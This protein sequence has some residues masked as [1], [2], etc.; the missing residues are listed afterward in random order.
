MAIIQSFGALQSMT[1][2]AP[3]WNQ[4]G[5]SVSL[6]GS[7]SQ[8]YAEI[9]RTQPNVRICID[10][11][12]RNIAQLGLHIFRR[13]SDTD[14]IRL[15]DHELARW[16]GK[17]NP[18]TRRYRLIETL[19]GDLGLYFNAFWLKVRYLD[20][21]GRP[22]I[23]LVRLP[24]ADMTVEGS[25]LPTHYTWTQN[26][27]R[28]EFALS[29]VVHFNG[30]NPLNPFMG[31]SP[32]ETLRRILA[33]EAAA[34]DH[35]EMFWRNAGRME[36][37]IEQTKDAP[38]WTQPQQ[39]QFRE[40]WQE[41]SAGGAKVGMTA[42][43]PKGMTLR[44]WSFS[45][46]DSEYTQGGKLRREVCAAAYH[47]PQPMVGIL[48]HATF[49]NIREQHKHLYQDTLGPW[50]EM[51]QQE[52]EG[53]LLIECEDQRDVYTEFNIAAKLSGSF[54]EQASSLQVLVGRPMM[55]P[56]EGRARL[57]LPSV[58][59]DPTA[60]QLA[61]QQGG[62]AASPEAA[63][64]DAARAKYYSPDDDEPTA[65][66]DVAAVIDATRERQR[67][68]LAKVPLVERPAVF[69]GDSERW[70]RE[71]ATDLLPLVR[72][73]AVAQRLARAANAETQTR[74]EGEAFHA[75]LDALEGKVDTP[76][77]MPTSPPPINLAFTVPDK[78]N[79]KTVTFR[80]DAQGAVVGADVREVA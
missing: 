78:S 48:D 6:Y 35:R 53:Q 56:N 57:N 79:A 52:I 64:P 28:K 26:G 32:L 42:V 5:S 68:R 39:D 70:T 65:R 63:A 46:K 2:P 10:F 17:P 59:D 51:I 33:E 44:P 30:Y 36:G 11:L 76:P 72:D 37:V 21:A 13:V 77:A 1:T 80:R 50:L 20:A 18:T 23:G 24:P 67:V 40:R 47:I 25:L 58:A 12:A 62:P 4:N 66:A 16:L 22:A 54:E 45:A 3:T 43:L 31:L 27:R 74:L 29:E 9:Y 60:D 55:T 15:S 7:Q 41:F 73:L 38:P 34:G 8:A 49:S 69:D 71:L 14:R 19:M 61:G 75:R